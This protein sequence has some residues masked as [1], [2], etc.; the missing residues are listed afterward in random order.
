MSVAQIE[1]LLNKLTKSELIQ[2]CLKTEATLCSKV[3]DLSEEVMDIL[4]HFKNLVEDIAGITSVNVEN[5]V[6]IEKQCSMRHWILVSFLILL[7]I[8][9]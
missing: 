7:I 5:L 1:P 3:V 8:V 4:T 6:K 9:S 2:L